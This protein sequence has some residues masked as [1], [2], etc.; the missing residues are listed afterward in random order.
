ML[1]RFTAGAGSEGIAPRLFRRAQ[2]NHRRSI[3]A[4]KG[5]T[6]RI[7]R[8]LPTRMHTVHDADHGGGVEKV[9]GVDDVVGCDQGVAE[10]CR[11][12]RRALA[13]TARSERQSDD[14][15]PSAAA[16]VTMPTLEMAVADYKR[17][18]FDVAANYDPSIDYIIQSVYPSLALLNRKRAQT[19][20][21]KLLF[22]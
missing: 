9:D 12:M 16:A 3:T 20:W 13:H 6:T 7:I 19:K 10:A 8:Q 15:M 17:R 22:C 11:S 2:H 4:K 1:G 14:S 21:T 18:V 5:G